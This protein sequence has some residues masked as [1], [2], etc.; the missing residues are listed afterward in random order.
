MSIRVEECKSKITLMAQTSSEK[1]PGLHEKIHKWLASFMISNEKL[2]KENYVEFEK[3]LVRK[4]K[5]E[6]ILEAQEGFW[7]IYLAQKVDGY[8]QKDLD[9]SMLFTLDFT[10]EDPNHGKKRLFIFQ[11]V[12]K[13]DEFHK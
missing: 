6:L 12:G 5:F 9:P 7:N 1:F 8:I 3:K 13:L 2:Y 11:K 4:I 10:K